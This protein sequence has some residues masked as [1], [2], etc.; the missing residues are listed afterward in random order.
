M[1]KSLILNDIFYVYVHIRKDTEQIFY[2]GKG[3]KCRASSK[4]GRNPYW[5]NIVNK[6]KGFVHKLIAIKLSESE[7]FLLEK[8]LIK[9]YRELGFELANITDG[10]DGVSGEKNYFYG[11]RFVGSDNAMFGKKRPD[12]T[13]YNKT[14]LNPLKG[15]SGGLSK[16]SKPLCVKFTNG[17][18]VFTE[19]GA[20]EFARQISMP[21]DSLTYCISTG[22]GMPKYNIEKAWRP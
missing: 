4:R 17:D 12:L 8:K 13:E 5:N 18:I 1:I 6:A 14:R 7:A 2:V 9:Q 22:N 19:V 11:K 3:K 21:E 16:T 20:Y 15:K 10:G